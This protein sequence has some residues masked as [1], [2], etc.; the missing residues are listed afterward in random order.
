MNSVKN[1]EYKMEWMDHLYHIYGNFKR[2]NDPEEWFYF[3]RRPE[4]SDNKES[5]KISEEVLR[6]ILI[7]EHISQKIVELLEDTFHYAEAEELFIDKYSMGAF[8]YYR[9]ILLGSEEFP[10]YRLFGEIDE[11]SEYDRFLNA[12]DE[13]YDI[14]SEDPAVYEEKLKNI[15]ILGIKHPY[16]ALAES[17]YH[18]VCKEYYNALNDLQ[19]LENCYY[20]YYQAGEILME[21]GYYAEAEEQF[22]EAVKYERGP[23]KRSLINAM[24]F[25]KCYSG[26]TQAALAFADELAEKGYEPFVEP[27][28][29]IFLEKI[30]KEIT[31]N[32]EAAELNEE[33]S[34]MLCEYFILTGDYENV[35]NL[36]RLSR[37]RGFKDSL[38]A[39]RLAEALVIIGREEEAERIIDDC[40]GG[41]IKLTG[42]KF[43]KIRELKARILIGKYKAKEAYEIIE[44]L[45]SKDAGNL[46]YLLT[47]AGMCERTGRM[48]EAVRIYSTL[49]FNVPENPAFSFA[50]GKCLL[51][52]EKPRRAH[53]LFEMAFKSAEDFYEAAYY[54]VQASIDSGELKAAKAEL[55]RFRSN[56]G[57]RRNKYLQGQIAE[58]EEK[59]NLAKDA[60]LELIEE[61]TKPEGDNEFLGEVYE[62]YLIVREENNAMV[63]TMI[64]ETRKAIEAVPGCANLWLRL[65]ML[66]RDSEVKP[67]LAKECFERAY[68]ADPY[69]E[70]AIACLIEHETN[71][72]NWQKALLYCDE[73]I[74]NTQDKD[75]YL[76]RANCDME[77]G[78]DEAFYADIAEF[79]RNGG[80]ER[81]TYELCSLF[82]TKTGDYE[83]AMSIYEKQLETRDVKEVPC[84]SSMAACL[85]KQGKTE[86]ACSLLKAAIDGGGK[87]PDWIAML[88]EIQLIN[89][90]FKDAKQTIKMIRKV[91]D[92][93]I[94]NDYHSFLKTRLALYSGKILK[95]ADTAESLASYEGEALCA[96]ICT[97]RGNYRKAVK[98]FSKLSEKE[99]S[100]VELYSWNALCHA[101]WGK[102][103]EAS[104][105]A[106]KGLDV[107]FGKYVPA[108][109][110]TRPDQ[111]CQYGLLAF[112]SGKTEN[113]YEAFEKA[114]T[115]VPC[116]EQPCGRCYEV[117]YG[118]GLC[119]ALDGDAKGAADAFETSLSI[120][121]HNTICR[122][123]YG[124][125]TK[126]IKI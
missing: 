12:F 81:D 108:D 1:V 58:M 11:D 77:L 101:L 62:R 9:Q 40:Y 57:S 26:K 44:N 21:I 111:L 88:L 110:L 19:N 113:A 107:F 114:K 16:T 28:K 109:M 17:S 56:L 6:Y 55:K 64:R 34:Q 7:Y 25:A 78:L 45:C 3:L 122:H 112:L 49:R 54:M 13:F 93:T 94:F 39:V 99:K 52:I 63:I 82:A 68:E 118:I 10:P 47:Y 29:I 103:N 23:L 48:D 126:S 87:N 51:K 60:Y 105:W 97:L 96:V 36:C 14:D 89:G 65:G 24:F 76:V 120:R 98:L 41:R 104:E 67:E 83:K 125:L 30:C 2:R 37:S 123:L 75:Y 80:D 119:K 102:R 32:R 106:E 85:C 4:M 42:D 71:D 43:D 27:L 66:H 35:V 121:P 50:L 33:E 8:D 124:K 59:F 70:G 79:L 5:K 15:K 72:D 117:Y 61:E 74:V 115:A 86:D 73:M 92:I 31:E 53:T 18:V 116:Y 20:K 90:F 69:N 46:S 38:W 84:Y 22:D 100:D 91:A 95:A